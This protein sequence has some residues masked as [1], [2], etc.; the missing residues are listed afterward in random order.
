VKQWDFTLADFPD[1]MRACVADKREH[2][3]PLCS[4]TLVI[5]PCCGRKTPA[6]TVLD[7]RT[8]SGTVVRGGGHQEPRDHE[9]LCD[10]CVHILYRDPSNPWTPSSLLEA[11]GAPAALVHEHR[12]REDAHERMQ[13][14]FAADRSHEPG[15]ALAEA[16]ARIVEAH[17][18]R[19][20]EEAYDARP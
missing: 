13:A 15:K 14:D 20:L 11:R 7:V 10:G 4:S 16:R 6:D 2:S 9:W 8:I 1:M 17:R 3:D 18:R 12:A 19:S 5:A